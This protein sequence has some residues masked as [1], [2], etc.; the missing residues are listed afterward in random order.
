MQQLAAAIRHDIEQ[1]V[2][3]YDAE[4]RQRPGHDQLP[5]AL[6]R[7]LERRVLSLIADCLEAGNHAALLEYVQQRAAQWETLGFPLAWFQ[8]A[9]IIP[10]E[11][12]TPL[13]SSIGAG[14]F[15]WQALNRSQGV[16]WQLLADQARQTEDRFRSIVETSHSG[17]V[18]IDDAFHVTY[19]NDELVQISGYSREE[20][21]GDDFRHLLDAESQQVVAHYYLRRQRGE[22]AP[23]RYEI[24]F[25]RKDGVKRYV[26]MSA[27]ALTDLND[28][29]YTVAQV[30]DV[31]ERKQTEQALRASQQLLQSVMD[32]IPQAVFWKDQDLR[33]LGCNQA[34]AEDAGLATPQ[35]IVGK[36]DYDMPWTAQ[37]EA[38]RADDRLVMESGAAKIN[39]EEAQT[40]PT[41]ELIWLRTSKV[42]MRD[43]EGKVTAVLGMYEDITKRREAKETLSRERN[44][45]RTLI[46]ALPDQIFVK[47][48]QGR[49]ML[50]NQADA[51]AMGLTSTD[52]ALGKTV[53]DMYPRELAD[54]YFADDMAVI[55]SGQPLIGREERGLTEDGQERW[56]L[57]TKVPLR[58]QAGHSL[59]LVGIARDITQRKQIELTLQDS[60]ERFRRFSEATT[61]GLVFHDQGRILDANPAI[62]ALFGFATAAELIGRNLL[63]FIVPDSRPLVVQKMQLNDVHPYEIQGIR[64]DGVIFPIETSTRTYQHGEQTI[65]ATA[66]RDITARKRLEQ[67]I[68]ESLARRSTQ[69]QTSVEVAQHVAAAPELGELFHR[70]VT[71][72][73]ERFN[74]YHVQLFR[75]VPAEDA[76]QLITG[77]GEVGQK[78]LAAG[79]QLAM[80]R[81]IVGTAA[82]TGQSILAPDVTR[83]LDWRPNPN[84]PDTK[85]E[86]AVPI[87]LGSGD[88]ESQ[89]HALQH[90]AHGS[91]DGFAVAAIDL[92]LIAPLTHQALQQG[93]PVVAITSHLGEGNQTTLIAAL[94]HEV[95]YLLG[96]QAGTWAQ[97]HVPD[98]QQV[99]IGV[100]TSRSQANVVERERGII[101]GIKSVIGE[102]IAIVASE[103]ALEPKEAAY[104]AE[105]WLRT[106]P[107]LN[108]I[109]AYND[110]T[111]LGAYQAARIMG[112]HDPDRFFIGGIDAVPEALEAIR[113]GGVYQATVSQPPE[114]MGISAVRTLVAAIKGIPVKPSYQ[115][116]CAPVNRSN[117]AEFA[118]SSRAAAVLAK[119]DIIS[120]E[121][122]AD[123][124]LSGLRLGLSVMTLANPFFATLAASAQQEAQR[125]GVQL[126]IN[127]PGRVL[128]VLDVQSDQANTLTDDDRLL[129]EGLCGQIASAMESTRR[130]EQLRQNEAMLSEALKI[131][132]LAYWEYDVTQDR[133]LFNDQFYTLFHTTVEQVGSYQ[134]SSAQYAQKFVHPDDLPI[135]GAEIE[136]ALNSIERHYSRNLVHRIRYADGGTGYISVN[137]NI[138]RDENGQILRY[139][140]A[141]Q[142]ITERRLAETQLEEL[143]G[144]VRESEQLLRTVIDATSDWIFIKDQEHRYRL[145]NQGYANSLH[146]PTE[147]FI[148]KND[149]DLGF[150]EDLVKGNVE[151]GIAGFWADDR[152]VMD[153]GQTRIIPKDLVMIDGALR[154]YSTI[155]TPLRDSAGRVWGV[156]AFARDITDLQ[157][158]QEDLLARNTQLAAFNKLGQSLAQLL[159]T[160]EVVEHVFQTVGEVLDN[161]NF[162]IALYNQRTQDITFPIYTIDGERRKV[163]GRPVG[164][165]MTEYVL[166]S[167]QPLLIARDVQNVADSLGIANIGR[168]AQ[169]Y[170]GIPLLSGDVALGVMTVQDYEH[171]NVYSETDVELLSAIATRMVAAL[172]NVR[173]YS[174]ESQRALQLQTASEV[175]RAA[176][177]IL[178]L[179]EL[180]PQAAE[181]IRE[182]FNLYYVGIFLLDDT[183]RWAVLR[184]GTG[185]AGQRML[186][187]NHRLKIGGNSMI[188]E[189][190]TMQQ[191]RI[192][193]D[194]GEAATRFN[195]PLLPRTRSEMALPLVS[196]GRVIG[197]ATIQS[198][199]PA[200]FA[201]DDITV[202]QSMAD[203]ISNAVE[204]ARLYEQTQAALREVDAINRRLTGEAWASYLRQHAGHDVLWLADDA[205]IAPPTVLEADEQIS[206][207]EITLEPEPDG[208]EATVTV[209]ILLRGQPI[210]AL[211]LRA[212]LREWDDDTR[213][214]LADIAGHIAQA[215]EN[216]R[217]V[218]QTQRAAERERLINEINA[219]VRQSVDLDAILRTAVNELGQSLKAARVV[220]R[221]GTTA[222]AGAEAGDGRG[223]T[224]D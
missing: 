84:L 168:S 94:E 76:V 72:V 130:L 174:I 216:A 128:G 10:E 16:V 21:L 105:G 31:S 138:D 34:F 122:L 46:D 119:Q 193:L 56:V 212:L 42:P 198:D 5:E 38:Y 190:V 1:L 18:I 99:Q 181:L 145:V 9:L 210:G 22:D 213:L 80:G 162:Y 127:D 2:D 129:L 187:N 109:V 85:G 183:E 73:K 60:E 173:L 40:T 133:F 69:V 169:C 117:A 220:A 41:G 49:L 199:Q 218:E 58:D 91:Y 113:Q 33:Y 155:K 200:A 139:Y 144:S 96:V 203:Q 180:L 3:R 184:A 208:E 11:I 32:N 148:G 165:G 131:A 89:V 137:I 27:V 36:T 132:K 51:R 146:I 156:L 164:N 93:K 13:I 126:I 25:V 219:R 116:Y 152:A 123:L 136:R 20:L 178:D 108:M 159:T 153:S 101:A 115:L 157:K 47:D 98:H 67:Q 48:M 61:E 114:V 194:V 163:A 154:T 87:K 92:A 82:A 81:G 141:N 59:G 224:H 177:S 88:A 204:N 7:E 24:A 35:H 118:G 62:V 186:A 217:L 75:Y 140:G 170:L 15:L 182:R 209:P 30:L 100:L 167:K 222:A 90:F 28:K 29:P 45:L 106:Y 65:R 160:E 207:G 43:A 171:E 66:V 39:Y 54:A 102:R 104:L 103:S 202:L 19:V 147:D 107:A 4:L 150:P 214:M 70:V 135:V 68:Q 191:A 111:A 71:L 120:T 63:E 52:E 221:V 175:S 86:L 6:R 206:A 57:T 12:L 192:A 143:L 110:A 161:R 125:L 188:S 121:T 53:Y 179:N 211:R 189:C 205:A 142:D 197:A 166:R 8:Q 97:Q 149:L 26:E 74:Y 185:E 83:D 77:Y 223:K 215:V 55:E 195:N 124:D 134:L 158:A 151:K 37:A 78:M 176:S 172:E 201:T 23:P 95:G 44:L 50:Y 112:W 17:V 64:S 79:H 14:N 196:R